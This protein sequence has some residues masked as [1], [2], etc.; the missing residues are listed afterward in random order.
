[1]DTSC[2]YKV[3]W[4]MPKYQKP[5]PT[6]IALTVALVAAILLCLIF[7]IETITDQSI[8]LELNQQSVAIDNISK[9]LTTVAGVAI[10]VTLMVA[11]EQL[12]QSTEQLRQNR[13]HAR[14]QA[15]Y[16]ALKDVR[17]LSDD[18]SMGDRFNLYYALFEQKRLGVWDEQMWGPVED[19][20]QMTFAHEHIGPVAT[21]YWSEKKN[22]YTQ[23]FQSCVE[24]IRQ[25]A[26]TEIV[27]PDG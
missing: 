17:N 9:L 2:S 14:A 18:A 13:N 23:E 22:N 5:G 25:A 6:I 24:L 7:L 11:I 4:Q 8:L 21:K 26:N 19:D 27:A 20:I 16:T 1:M 15:I 10:V 12:R 3:N